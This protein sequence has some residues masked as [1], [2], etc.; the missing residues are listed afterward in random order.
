MNQ[1]ITGLTIKR[2]REKNK[3]TQNELAEKLSVTDKSISKWETGRGYPDITLIEDI[4]KVFNVSITELFSGDTVENKNISANVEK[5][6]FYVC[7]ICGNIITSIGETMVSC[8]GINLKPLEAEAS[9]EN[10]QID[11]SRVEDE[12]YVNINHI[13]AKNHYISFIAAVS[14][15]RLQLVKLYPESSA[16]TRFKI[17][18]VNKIYYYCNKDG[19]YSHPILDNV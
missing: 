12:Y 19:L 1:Y 16:E 5:I 2:L 7:P 9:D 15:D 17:S 3:L 10:H 13:M 6:K 11:V 8:H 14:K 18:G 4:A